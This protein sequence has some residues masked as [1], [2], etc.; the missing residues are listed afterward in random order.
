MA[1]YFQES[2]LNGYYTKD[3]FSLIVK[4]FDNLAYKESHTISPR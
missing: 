1:R 2:R 4:V 3:L